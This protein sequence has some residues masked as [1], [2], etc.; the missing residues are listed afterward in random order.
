METS[1]GIGH[2]PDDGSHIAEFFGILCLCPLVL[3]LREELFVVLRRVIVGVKK[4]LE[5]VETYDIAPFSSVRGRL[6]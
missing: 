1:V 5:V 6:G 4:V 3:S 2:R